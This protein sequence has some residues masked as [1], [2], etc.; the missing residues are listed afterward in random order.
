MTVGE[1]HR[2]LVRRLGAVIGERLAGASAGGASGLADFDLS[3]TDLDVFAVAGGTVTKEEKRAI[4]AELRHE[5]LP[6]PARG[7]EFVLYPE[8]TARTATAEAGFV[9][10]LNT[11]P[12]MDFRVDEE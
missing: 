2:E 8:T 12:K 7:L 6:C 4:V 5:S 1:Y 11:G 10:N 9:L 3:R